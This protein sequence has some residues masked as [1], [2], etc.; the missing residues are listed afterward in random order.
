MLKKRLGSEDPMSKIK[1]T[2]EWRPYV[3]KATREWRPYVGKDYQ[4]M[5]ASARE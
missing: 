3:G 1:S 2:R 4:V 5:L